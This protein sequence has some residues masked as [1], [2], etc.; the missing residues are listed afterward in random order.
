MGRVNRILQRLALPATAAAILLASKTPPSPSPG[1]RFPLDLPAVAVASFGEYR[2]DH[3]HPGVDFSTGGKDGLPVHAVEAGRIFRLKVEWRGYGRALY[4]QHPDGRISVYAHLER[5]EDRRLGLEKRV[6]EEK[7]RRGV[8]YPGDIFLD[9]PIP[10]ERG[11]VIAYSGESGAGLPHLHFEMRRGDQEPSDPLVPGWITAEAPPV[12][13]KAV[14]RAD[15]AGT[16]IDGERIQEVALKEGPDGVY[17]PGRTLAVSGPFLPEA[18]I[19]SRDLEGHRLGIRALEVRVDGVPTY[20]LRLESFRFSQYPEVGLLLDHVRSRLSPPEYTYFLE[21]LAGNDLGSAG[22]AENPWPPLPP[23]E[24]RLTVEALGAT[25]GSSRAVIPFRVLPPVR[26][27]WEEPPSAGGRSLLRF[28]AS[29]AELGPRLQVSYRLLGQRAAIPCQQREETPEGEICRLEI[30]SSAR[31]ITAELRDGPLLLG[32]ATRLFPDVSRQLPLASR[33]A[34]EP[35]RHYV[36]LHLRVAEGEDPPGRLVLRGS[37]GETVPEL[38]E[39]APGELLASVPAAVWREVRSLA[40]ERPGP[41]AS[42][43]IPL[44]AVPHYAAAGAPLDLADCGIRLTAPPGSF[45]QDTPLQCGISESVPPLPGGLAFL[46]SPVRLLP[47]G[48]PLS[49]KATLA[50]PLPSDPHPERLGIYRLDP[51]ARAWIFQGGERSEGEIRLA[52][53]R[54]DTFALVR[55]DSPPRILGVDPSGGAPIRS[56]R[57]LFRVR[58]EDQ[59]SGLNY[60]G[61][62]LI[63]DGTELETEFDPD[64]GWATAL[65]PTALASGTHEGTAWAVDRAGNRSEALAFR[66]RIR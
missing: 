45:Y 65:P 38:V 47:E 59:G 36:D 33:L 57:P 32:R 19:C 13:E 56:S 22:S 24:H 11:E 58:V 27:R 15:S 54:L 9:P 10:V 40:L 30:P 46:G 8:R 51:A 2:P 62:H 7:R 34:V 64:R 18:S 41:P 48:T 5:Y 28:G 61:V 37:S 25:G 35:A 31:G 20:I 39:A 21:R 3:L 49:G 12:F 17:A 63:V 43:A 42:G 6:S 52:M 14:L 23:G 55:D 60:D 44:S 1:A 16:W 53:G 4:L 26:L 66:I 50:F 29:R